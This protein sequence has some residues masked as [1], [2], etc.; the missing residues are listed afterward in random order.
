MTIQR[1]IPSGPLLRTESRPALDDKGQLVAW[2]HKLVSVPLMKDIKPPEAFKDGI[3]YYCLWGLAD[4]EKSPMWNARIQYEI[5]NL[6]IE[7]LL[8]NSAHADLALACGPE[9][10]QCLCH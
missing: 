9:W 2:S 3:D 4:D 8:S 6:Y 7:L 1:A 10:P 5:P